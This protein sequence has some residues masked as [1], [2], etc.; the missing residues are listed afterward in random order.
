MFAY[1]WTENDEVEQASADVWAAAACSDGTG[2][3]TDLFFSDEIPDIEFAKAICAV[4]PLVT[5]CLHTALA[6]REPA[7]VWGGQLFSNGAVVAFKRKRGRP[8]KA[9]KAVA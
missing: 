6:R 9:A 4:C 1:S 5:P 3:L 8:P 2:S 7:G